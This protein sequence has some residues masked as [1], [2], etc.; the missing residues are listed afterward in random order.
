MGFNSVMS[1]IARSISTH[2]FSG[3]SLH[4]SLDRSVRIDSLNYAYFM[5][6]VWRCHHSKRTTETELLKNN[7]LTLIRML[8]LH[9]PL[10][11][12]V[13]EEGSVLIEVVIIACVN[14]FHLT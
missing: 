13:D 12:G 8:R 1:Q 5:Y 11:K 6:F 10:S 3:Y 14:L 7:T 2:C 4:K 9:A